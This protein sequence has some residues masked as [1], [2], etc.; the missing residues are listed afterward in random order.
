MKIKLISLLFVVLT[1]TSCGVNT[2]SVK[3]IQALETGVS[4]PNSIEEIQ[5]AINKYEARVEDVVTAQAQIGI[6]YKMLASRYLDSK[7]YG[8]ALKMFQKSIEFY[9]TNQNLYY[10]IGVCAGYMAKAELDYSASGLTTKR[11]NY[12]RLAESGY[13]RAIELEDGYVRALYGLGILYV[14]ELDESDKA[15][16]YLEKLLTIDTKHTDAMFVLA[17]AYYVN[18]AY[19]K[20]IELYDRIEKLSTSPEKKAEAQANRKVVLDAQF[21]R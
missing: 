10:Y 17:R 6:W 18:E 9:P 19:D 8:E 21:T 15:I 2:K 20:A 3:R 7:M 14:F 4:A 5:D 13:K 12:L 1:L 11:Q 16:P